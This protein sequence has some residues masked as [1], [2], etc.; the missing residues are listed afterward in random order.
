MQWKTIFS[1]WLRESGDNYLDARRYDYLTKIPN[2]FLLIDRLEHLIAQS[3]RN[4]NIFALLFI[5]L[6]RFK[7]INDTKGNAFG[8]QVLI[9]TSSR[10]KQSIRSSDTVARIGGD[11]FVVLLE[12]MVSESYVSVMVESITN[13]LHSPFVIGDEK[14]EV[15][16]SVGVAVYPNE[17]TTTDALL[18]VADKAMYKVKQ[19]SRGTY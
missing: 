10:L 2:R 19:S 16:C 11:E 7:M 13:A 3:E 6:D 8:D 15:R 9:E 5:D 4:K 12:N 14:F 17:G 1:S 18:A